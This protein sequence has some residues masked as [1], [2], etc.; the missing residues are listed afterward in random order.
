MGLAQRDSDRH[1]YADYCSWPDEVRYEL[2]DGIAYAMG[3][4]PT[5]SHQKILGDLF[6][7]VA[8]ALDGSPCEVYIATFDV[9]L[10]RAGEADDLVDTVVQ[11]DLTIVCDASK[12]DERGCRGAPDWIV[13]VLS[14]STATHDHVR[15][16][17]VYERAGVREFW[18]LHPVDRMVTMY[19]LDGG[20]YGFPD[21]H[22]TAGTLSVG[23]LADVVIDW[24]RIF[25]AVAT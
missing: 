14:P 17:Q 2:I 24:E 25:G 19:R 10:P 8:D 15:K 11:P 1:T 6:R 7:Q 9:R 3:P 20:R 5:R 21:I 13:E 23:V 16:R 12:L 4:A 22:E 18:L